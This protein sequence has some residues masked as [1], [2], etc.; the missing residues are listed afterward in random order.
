MALGAQ[1]PSA[2]SRCGRDRGLG[3]VDPEGVADCDEEKPG[4]GGWSAWPTTTIWARW[5]PSGSG[6]A[7]TVNLPLAVGGHRDV[8][9]A[10]E[11]A[12]AAADVEVEAAARGVQ[13]VELDEDLQVGD[14]AREGVEDLAD[15]D[16]LGEVGVLVA[17]NSRVGRGG[18]LERR[19]DR[20][21]QRPGGRGPGRSRRPALAVARGEE[22]LNSPSS[23]LPTRSVTP[24]A[25]LDDDRVVVGRHRG[26]GQA[27]VVE[28]DHCLA[29]AVQVEL[30]LAPGIVV[31][32]DRRVADSPVSRRRWT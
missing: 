25:A 15:E 6:G 16:R 28:R 3:L 27:A 32:V 8:E 14:R 10:D 17:R 1:R 22:P 5:K 2:V 19:D 4:S 31:Q 7:G 24:S 12:A 20:G 11:A 9:V 30:I 23:S 26:L 18:H 13:A 21:L 29:G